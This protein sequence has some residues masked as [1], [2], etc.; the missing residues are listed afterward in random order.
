MLL[1]VLG[2]GNAWADV[3]TLTENFS[4][5]TATNDNYDC[6]SSLSTSNNRAGFDYSWSSGGGGTVFKNGIKLGGSSSTGFVE[7]G[8]ILDDIPSGTE[9][10]VK[11]YA[12]VW[13]NDGGKIVATYHDGNGDEASYTKEAAN[14]AIT[15]TKSAYSASA[16]ASSTDF[17]FTKDSKWKLKIAS[18]AKRVIIDKVEIVYS[19]SGGSEPEPTKYTVSIASDIT[20]GT[21]TATPTSAAEGTTVTL[22]STPNT[23]YEFGAWSVKGADNTT[24]TVTDNKFA[25]PAQNVTVSATFTEATPAV[26]YAELPFNW[27]GGGKDAF[28]ALNGIKGSGLGT[29]YATSNAPYQIKLDSDGDYFQIKTNEAIGL[30]TVDVKMLGGSKASSITVKESANGADFTDVETL[31]ISGAQNNVLNLATTKNL[32][33]ESRYVRFVFTKGS[34]V[35]VGAITIAKPTSTNVTFVATDGAS[36]YA[37]F[38]SDRVVALDEVFVNE[39]ENCLAT[40]KAYAVNV[41]D[42]ALTLTDLYDTHSDGN[43]TYIPKN[44]G[45]LLK[46]TLEDGYEFDGNVTLDYADE[47]DGYLS[48]VTA[49]L[50]KPATES[51]TGDFNFYKLAYGDFE[52]KTGLGFYWGATDGAAFTCKTGTAYLA[53]P[54]SSASNVRGFAFGGECITGIKSIES[55]QA[56]TEIFNLQGQRISRLQQGVNIVN[57]KKVIR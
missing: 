47:F 18:S 31:P 52:N 30:C 2:W 56:N 53:V 26:D 37:T 13:N 6:S 25:M 28:T 40:V 19:T 42:E 27:A 43:Y 17:T 23:G 44:T 12:A 54:K 10:T 49:N 1:A 33:A 11:V 55:A 14:A 46:Y 22:S 48:E 34:N 7:S 21:V 29:D 4:A 45:V 51:M 8:T 57:G 50:L 41:V 16:F 5:S 39:D 36:Y 24:I 9:F 32:K 15:S 35:G 38:S 20:N 3:V